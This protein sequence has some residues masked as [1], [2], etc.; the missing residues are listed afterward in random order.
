MDITTCI[1][2]MPPW[3]LT[4]RQVDEAGGV[5]D[6]DGVTL[7]DGAVVCEDDV[8]VAV[9]VWRLRRWVSRKTPMQ[10]ACLATRRWH[11]RQWWRGSATGWRWRPPTTGDA[12]FGIWRQSIDWK[13]AAVS[14]RCRDGEL[15]V[16][17][18]NWMA[19]DDE[20]CRYQPTT[21]TVTT[22]DDDGRYPVTMKSSALGR[23]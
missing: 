21:T 22:D 6:E 12:K 19:I 5:L 15:T 14:T 2:V 17:S 4:H 18:E 1:C 13:M 9:E 23:R 10:V 16:L 7:D 11:P 3:L 8:T 20:D